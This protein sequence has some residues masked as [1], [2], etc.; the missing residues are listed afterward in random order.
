MKFCLLSLV[1]CLLYSEA[2]AQTKID[3]PEVS[4]VYM[5]DKISAGRKY[6][7]FFYKNGSNRNQE[8]ST[9][10]EIQLAHQKFLF[11]LKMKG[12]LLVNGP[13]TDEDTEYRGVGIFD[14]KDK[15]YVKQI[16]LGDPA[17][18]AGRLI[19]ETYYWFGIPGDTLTK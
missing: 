4:E 8:K 2:I 11:G 6:V 19:V 16:L 14:S 13:V 1:V 17:V 12:L 10:E 18:K 9:Y 5:K 15:E 3:L 7:I